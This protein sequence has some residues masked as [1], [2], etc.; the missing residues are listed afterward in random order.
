MTM[1]TH[2]HLAAFGTYLFVAV[3]R[4]GAL[5]AALRLAEAVVDDIDATCSRFRDD[6]DLSRANAS[7][8][9]WVGVDPL[10][11]AAVDVA[12]EA[13]AATDGLVHPLLGRTL[14]QLGYDRDFRRLAGATETLLPGEHSGIQPPAIDAWRTIGLDPEGAIRVPPGTALDLGSTAKAWTADLIAAAIETELGEPALVSVGGDLRIAAPDGT[15]WKIAVSEDPAGP[16]QQHVSMAQG[17]LATSSTRVRRWTHRG[18]V[19]HHLLDPRTGR[20]VDEV[21]RTVSATGPSCVAA[22]T[23]STAAVVMGPSAPAWLADRGVA[24]RLKPGRGQVVTTDGWPATG[25]GPSRRAS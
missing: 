13:A 18:A 14:V 9:T 1:P 4:A 5:A 24:A 19:R 15:R 3:R 17:G 21:W 23:A 12:C 25:S 8:G 7:P 2:A 16:V 20:P 11:V 10:L 22:N 6:S